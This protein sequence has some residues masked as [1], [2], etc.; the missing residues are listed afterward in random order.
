MS[1]VINSFRICCTLRRITSSNLFKPEIPLTL[2]LI[3]ANIVRIVGTH[4]ILE[5]TARRTGIGK[6]VRIPFALACFWKNS[7]LAMA[8]VAMLFPGEPS[9]IVP[10]SVSMI[11]EQFYFM[12]MIRY[13]GSRLS[14]PKPGP[15][16]TA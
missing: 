1:Y 4:L 12:I 7:G 2:S 16:Q 10:I 15:E 14:G 11:F 5:I 8:M 13:Y 3:A 9:L 6:D